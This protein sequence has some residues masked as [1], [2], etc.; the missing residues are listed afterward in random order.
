MIYLDD[1]ITWPS[2]LRELLD[3]RLGA[4]SAFERERQRVDKLAETDWSYRY[5][6]PSNPHEGARERTVAEIDDCLREEAVAGYHCTRLC[7]DEIEI[8]RSTGLRP[9]S[10]DLARERVRRRVE[11]GDF[12]LAVGARILAET[13][14]DDSN[15]PERRSGM[16]WFVF[17]ANPLREEAGVG[18]F[19]AY[20]GGE[21]LYVCHEEDPEVGPAL[22]AAGTAC[23]VEAAVAVRAI[24]TYCSVGERVLRCFLHRRDIETGHDPDVEGFVR[25]PVPGSSICRII[26]RKD[27]DF[28]RLTRCST[29][30]RR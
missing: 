15:L 12:S 18:R 1:E 14:A 3:D 23:I 16:T 30:A 26:Q 25:E 27:A 13:R 29:W 7:A 4:L 22:R 28:E 19:F 9:L 5:N 21:A 20:W 2:S 11:A 24:E 17:T 8:I 6:P 10:P